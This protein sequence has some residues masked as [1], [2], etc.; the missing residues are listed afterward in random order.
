MASEIDAT[1][2]EDDIL[3]DKALLRQNALVAKNEITALQSAISLAGQMA[4]NDAMF[5][6][7]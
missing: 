1:V 6:S 5:D 4:F 7:L 3:V 2:P